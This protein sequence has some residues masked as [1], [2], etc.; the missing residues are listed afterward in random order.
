MRG[1][2]VGVADEA[3]RPFPLRRIA[4]DG[5]SVGHHVLHLGAGAVACLHCQERGTGQGKAHL[6]G[7]VRSD[8]S[9]TDLLQQDGFQVGQL[10]QAAADIGERLAG[11]DPGAL[12]VHQLDVEAGAAFACHVLQPF[13]H[14]PRRGNHRAAH[15]H[16]VGHPLVAEPRDDR[17][18]AVEV[19]VG[20]RRDVG[21][22]IGG[23]TASG[24]G[25]LSRGAA[26]IPPPPGTPV[27]AT[28]PH[29]AE[30]RRTSRTARSDPLR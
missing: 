28:A 2:V 26:S 4:A 14:Q 11:A 8:G 6:I 27:P 24:H 13:D 15:E 5:G 9:R 18:R 7:V 12:V 3:L 10:H 1:P 20:P 30:D 19:A 25:R 22:V 16:R 23:A 29:S 17:A 21:G